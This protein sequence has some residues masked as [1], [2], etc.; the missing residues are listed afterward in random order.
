MK[1]LKILSGRPIN[2]GESFK[3]KNAIKIISAGMALVICALCLTGCGIYSNNSSE[4]GKYNALKTAEVGNYIRFG[5]YI[6]YRT[7]TPAGIVWL[8]LAKEGEKALVIS[9]YALDEQP[10]DSFYDEVTW[11]NCSVRE[12]LNETFINDAFSIEEQDMIQSTTVSADYNPKYNSWPGNDTTDKIF[13]LSVKEVNMYFSTDEARKCAPTLFAMDQGAFT[14]DSEI[15][16]GRGTCVWM[17]R[18]PGHS[19]STKAVVDTDGSVKGWGSATSMHGT[20]RPA[21]WIDLGA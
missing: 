4:G 7:N 19:N 13:L 10:Y 6:Q 2:Y 15:V 12:W 9:K 18:T 5:S 14:S 21:M 1:C 17:L 3:T 16:D 20:I 8:V 11:E